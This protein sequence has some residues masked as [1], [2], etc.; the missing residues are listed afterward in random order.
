MSRY[1]GATGSFALDLAKFAQ[2]SQDAI[3]ETLQEVVIELGN[4]LIRMSPVD[5]GRFR[6]NWQFSIGT[7]ASGSLDTNDPSGNETS[8]RIVGDSILFKAGETA[9]IV[10]NLPYAIP[11]EYG[12]SEQAPSGMVRITLARFQAIVEE[13]IRTNKV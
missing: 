8:A 13:A 11:L 7:P 1:A 2:Q 5:T 4:S 6:G 9:Y 3:D 10:N 12:H